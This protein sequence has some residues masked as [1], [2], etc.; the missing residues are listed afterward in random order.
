MI[1]RIVKLS[2]RPDAVEEFMTI[3]HESKSL[4]RNAPGCLRL[5]LLQDTNQP[6]VLST[7][8]WWNHENDL[9][10]Y[11]HSSLFIDTWAKT[12]PLFNDK[13]QAW[14]FNQVEK[15]A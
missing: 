1:V 2:F 15:L 13:P 4:I 7:Y 11:R 8:S 3:F 14:S 10:N 6:N 9:E 12:K 5:E